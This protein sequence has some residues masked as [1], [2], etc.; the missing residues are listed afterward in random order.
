M[1]GNKKYTLNNYDASAYPTSTTDKSLVGW[2]SK[3][4][5]PVMWFHKDC[6]LDRTEVS[7]RNN[8]CERVKYETITIEPHL[9]DS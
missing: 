1:E 3:Y 4:G 7:L 8:L 9:K 6:N 5:R 2:R